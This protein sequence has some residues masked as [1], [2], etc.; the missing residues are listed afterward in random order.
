[1]LPIVIIIEGQSQHEAALFLYKFIKK[2]YYNII[3]NHF[4]K[5]KNR[6]KIY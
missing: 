2:E 3:F 5:Y 4:Q 6:Q 1:M